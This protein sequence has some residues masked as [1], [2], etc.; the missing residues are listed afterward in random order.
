VFEQGR[1]ILSNKILVHEKTILFGKLNPRVLKVWFVESM[2]ESR[3][4]ASTE[5]IPIY[6]VDEAYPDYIYY[7]CQSNL[8]VEPSKRLVSGSTPSR[9]RVDPKSFYKIPIPLPP[10]S[11]QRSIAQVLHIIQETIQIRRE[12][13]ELELERKAALMQY[14][15]KH[16]IHNEPIKR[17]EIGE[18]PTSW[19]VLPLGDV[20]TLQRGFDITQSEQRTG[21]VPVV[22]SSGILSYHDTTKVKGPGVIIGRKGS[23]GTVFFIDDD[24]WPHDT[25]LCF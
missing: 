6:A 21:K 22:S 2:T 16:G 17:T 23:L 1:Q 15:F 3:K 5:F 10:L 18:I 11:E 9:Q 25:T 19:I 4:I 7:L 14:F 13:L 8:V 20:A 24:Y 12:E